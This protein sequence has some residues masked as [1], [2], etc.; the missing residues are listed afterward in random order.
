MSTF[1]IKNK[2]KNETWENIKANGLTI[3]KDNGNMAFLNMEFGRPLK[4]EIKIFSLDVNGGKLEIPFSERLNPDIVSKVADFRK[5]IFNTL[6]DFNEKS[7]LDKLKFKIL[8]L[9]KKVKDGSISQDELNSKHEY[10][11]EYE[12][13]V[14]GHVYEFLSMYDALEFLNSN[15]QMFANKKVKVK[16]NV[17][18]S[19]WQ[20]KYYTSFIPN[21]FEIVPDHIENELNLNL[22]IYF[23]PESLVEN[24]KECVLLGYLCNYDKNLKKDAFFPK[25][26][27]IKKDNQDVYSFLYDIFSYKNK[28]QPDNQ[29][30]FH[31]NCLAEAFRGVELLPITIDDLTDAQKTMVKLGMAKV[32][33]FGVKKFG[34]NMEKTYIKSPILSG[35]FA[36]GAKA[37]NIDIKNFA[38]LI[39]TGYQNQ[40]SPQEEIQKVPKSLLDDLMGR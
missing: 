14:A 23:L 2:N 33:D 39:S 35:E 21:Y 26:F 36:S 24:E 27:T 37:S 40:A 19:S 20:G 32:E 13:R 7:D 11:Q 12:Q 17:E 6:D 3:K 10:E 22:D 8:A 9:N 38:K 31:I 34:D 1:I 5:I 25:Q 15:H 4:Q 29:K 16:G 18:M 30:V 28:K